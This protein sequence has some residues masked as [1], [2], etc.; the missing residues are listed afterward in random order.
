ML[1][2]GFDSV[3]STRRGC[4]RWR[5]SIDDAVESLNTLAEVNV[6]HAGVHYQQCRA[7]ADVCR[8]A[9]APAWSENQR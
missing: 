6:L 4:V 5:E 3:L 9:P 8:S 1:I 2:S 7:F